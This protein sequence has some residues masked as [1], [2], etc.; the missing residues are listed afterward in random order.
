M[1]FDERM[2]VARVE[3]LNLRELRIWVREGWVRPAHSEAGPIFDE[4]DV[5]RIRLLCDLKKDMS[6]P[7]EALP[8]V[9]TLI[10]NL[11]Q[12][13]RELCALTEAL[14][15]QPE[16]VRRTIVTKFRTLHGDM[17]EAGGGQ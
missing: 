1:S 11:H 9:L 17:N 13:R 10:D 8:V 3:R 12:T 4:L 5:A 16:G 2:V 6:L 7:T 15:E 14:E